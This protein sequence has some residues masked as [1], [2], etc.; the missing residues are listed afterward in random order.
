MAMYQ[1]L[2]VDFQLT[3]CL[4][5]LLVSQY[6]LLHGTLIIPLIYHEIFKILLYEVLLR[7]PDS[8]HAFAKSKQ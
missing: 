8:A 1:A 3:G 7:G 6:H 5:G 2:Q 4:L